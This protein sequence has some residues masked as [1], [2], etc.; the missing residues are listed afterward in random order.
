MQAKGYHTETYYAIYALEGDT[1]RICRPESEDRPTEFAS[2][3]DSGIL[4]LT[5]KRQ[6]LPR[7]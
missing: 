5:A 1:L 7:P 2:Q 6:P 4:L 3:P